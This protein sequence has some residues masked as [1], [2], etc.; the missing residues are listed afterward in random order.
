MIIQFGI[1]IL[2]FILLIKGADIF[3]EASSKLA[4]KMHIPEIVIGLT[5]VAFGTSAPEAAISITSAYSGAADLSIGNIIGSN[6]MNVLFVL[7]VTGVIASLAVKKNTIRYEIPFVM[8]ITIVLAVL[9]SIGGSISRFDGMILL[10]LFLVFLGYLYWLTTTGQE[11]SLDEVSVA[12]EKDKTYR[13]LFFIVV[14]IMMIIGGS[15]LTIDSAT[16]IATSFGVDD[17]IIGLTVVA[18]GTSLPEL[19]TSITAALKG[20]VDISVGNI[21]GS[22]IFNILL[23]LGT[24][25]V[26]APSAVIFDHSFIMDAFVALAAIVLFFSLTFKTN[27]FNRRSA[28]VL[29]AG[30]VAYLF[31]II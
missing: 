22:N 9:G 25:S 27:I 1:L 17:R 26:V 3:V 4:S 18:L 12:E 14:G 28:M 5:I 21:V 20:N 8:L 16:S 11:T 30:Y 19:I 13:L 23:V 10:G 7:G 15:N 24:T 31:T 2:G 29:V 6:I